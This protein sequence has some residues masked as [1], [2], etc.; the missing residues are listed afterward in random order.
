MIHGPLREKIGLAVRRGVGLVPP[1]N[2]PAAHARPQAAFRSR[3]P[4]N[5][6]TGAS[7]GPRP[8]RRGECRRA[9]SARTSSTKRRA[10]QPIPQV[11]ARQ[12]AARFSSASTLR[13]DPARQ[14]VV[15]LSR[16]RRNDILPASNSSTWPPENKSLAWE[17]KTPVYSS[18]YM[19]LQRTGRDGRQNIPQ[20]AISN[21]ITGQR[22]ALGR[23]QRVAAGRT[24]RKDRNNDLRADRYDVRPGPVT[25]LHTAPSK[26][27]SAGGPFPASSAHIKE[28][29]PCAIF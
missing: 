2:R 7:G 4:R 29:P 5:G 3:D 8:S 20:T 9:G 14:Q 13:R 21:E 10:L 1:L 19:W 22:P 18:T 23:D 12:R 28:K 27:P 6:R 16:R 24:F 11:T 17:S 25:Q 26:A 15:S